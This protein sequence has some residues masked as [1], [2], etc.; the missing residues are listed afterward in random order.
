M[1]VGR[2]EGVS[3]TKRKLLETEEA[4]SR[5]NAPVEREGRV[6]PKGGVTSDQCLFP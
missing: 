2:E 4:K 3:W 5:A 1:L 6:D